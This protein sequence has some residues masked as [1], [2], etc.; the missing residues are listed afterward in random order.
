VASGEDLHE[1]S[2]H[3]CWRP[4]ASLPEIMG[5]PDGADQSETPSDFEAVRLLDGTNIPKEGF[6]SS[7][8][9]PDSFACT[10]GDDYTGSKRTYTTEHKVQK[11]PAEPDF[12]SDTTFYAAEVKVAKTPAFTDARGVVIP[13]YEITDPSDPDFAYPDLV[14]GLYLGESTIVDDAVTKPKD[15]PYTVTTAHDSDVPHAKYGLAD[16]GNARREV[17]YTYLDSLRMRGLRG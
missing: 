2:K 17:I 15:L 5:I 16:D 7:A 6:Y 10:D 9:D 8:V 3:L 13:G 14:D 4:K 12:L 1:F 11:A